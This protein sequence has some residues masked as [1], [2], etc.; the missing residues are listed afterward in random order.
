DRGRMLDAVPRAWRDDQRAIR[1]GVPVDYEPESPRHGIE[2]RGGSHATC[3][4]SRNERCHQIGMQRSDVGSGH[5]AIG[6]I[7]AGFDLELLGADLHA[8]ARAVERGKSVKTVRPALQFPDED[9]K[10]R[11]GKGF[12]VAHDVEPADLLPVDL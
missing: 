7:G 12:G 9:W 6:R 8:S 11:R 1:V 2:A 4:K 10:C 3:R 5:W